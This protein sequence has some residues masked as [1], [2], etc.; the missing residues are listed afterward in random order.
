MLFERN[1]IRKVYTL[2]RSCRL[3]FCLHFWRAAGRGI[4]ALCLRIHFLYTLF[5]DLFLSLFVDF[6]PLFTALHFCCASS[7]LSLA[8]KL[9]RMHRRRFNRLHCFFASADRLLQLRVLNGHPRPNLASRSDC[10]QTMALAS[11]SDLFRRL[12]THLN[13]FLHV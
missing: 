3:R 2:L 6:L 13:S 9:L 7:L 11:S 10:V 12:W 1:K 8:A 4:S 5:A